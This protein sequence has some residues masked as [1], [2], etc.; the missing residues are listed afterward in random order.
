MELHFD[1]LLLISNGNS[2]TLKQELQ[3]IQSFKIRKSLLYIPKLLDEE[4]YEELNNIDGN[5]MFYI[6]YPEFSKS[7]FKQAVTLSNIT[8]TAVSDVELNQHGHVIEEYN[9]EVS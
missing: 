3:V 6:V 1:D 9:L 8:K 4:F 7:M 5:A 2:E